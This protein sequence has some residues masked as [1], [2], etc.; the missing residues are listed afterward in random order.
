MQQMTVPRAIFL[1]GLVVGVLDIAD[2]FIFF[3][4]R[5]VSPVRILQGIAG[6]LLGRDAFA[7]GWP[8]AAL[9]LSLHF[10][11]ATVVVAVYVLAS[12]QLVSLVKAPLLTGPLYGLAVWLAMNFVVLPLSAAGAPT[13]RTV[14]VLNGLLIHMVGVG[15]PSAL[16]AR[17]ARRSAA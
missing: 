11:I 14:V 6:G 12:R 16:F 2:A 13:F 9:G 17:A 4:F 10:L 1:G 15:L 5:G 8:T 3:G 7:G